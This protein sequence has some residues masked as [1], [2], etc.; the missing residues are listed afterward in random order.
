M[1][2]VVDLTISDISRLL[3]DEYMYKFG[4]PELYKNVYDKCEEWYKP[5]GVDDEYNIAHDLH[6]IG[7]LQL[8]CIPH[9]EDGRSAI[10]REWCFKKVKKQKTNK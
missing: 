8:L 10:C 2:E 4:E 9:I 7:A 6:N 1:E 3:E 5:N